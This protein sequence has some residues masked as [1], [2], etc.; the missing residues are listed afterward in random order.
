MAHVAQE[1]YQQLLYCTI[2]WWTL[3]YIVSKRPIYALCTG[4]A[5]TRPSW[6]PVSNLLALHRHRRS[7]F[8]LSLAAT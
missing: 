1:F 2:A 6:L 7:I 5:I 8:L 4:S 3:V